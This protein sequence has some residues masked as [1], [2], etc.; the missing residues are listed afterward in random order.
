VPKE[1]EREREREKEK[2]KKERKRELSRYK[3]C[4]FSFLPKPWWNKTGPFPRL[5]RVTYK[6]S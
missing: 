1:R 6:A 2:R 5:R 3:E 4:C